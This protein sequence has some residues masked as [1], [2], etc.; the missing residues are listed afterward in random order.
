ML[1]PTS[2][3][4]SSLGADSNPLVSSS[5]RIG[6]GSRSEGDGSKGDEG[7]DMKWGAAQKALGKV[8]DVLSQI[9]SELNS[10]GTDSNRLRRLAATSL[11]NGAPRFRRVAPHEMALQHQRLLP[12][13]LTCLHQ[14]SPI[15]SLVGRAT[16]SL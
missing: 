11:Q 8:L 3:V 12:S 1:P 10:N 16:Q 6:F 15:D 4:S 9:F 13:L 2:E 7:L 14:I 5:C